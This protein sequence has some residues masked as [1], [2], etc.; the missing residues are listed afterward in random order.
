MVMNNSLLVLA[1]HLFDGERFVRSPVRIDIAGRMIASVRPLEETGPADPGGLEAGPEVIDARGCLVV[2]G[3]IN[4]HT[5]V[6]RGGMFRPDEPVSIA[7]IV[8]N[9]GDLLSAGVTTVGEMGNAP[10][11]V[12]SLRALFARRPDWGPDIVACGPLLTVE[13]G[14]PLDWMPWLARIAGVALPC[15][16]PVAG[17]NAVRRVAG[18]G[19]DHIKIVIMH[20]SYAEK[21]LPTMDLETATAV[22][23]EAH[24]QG[25]RALC[26]AHYPEDY[27]KALAAGV[28]ALLHSCFEPIDDAMVERF[29]ASG[30]F[31]G[32]TLSVFENALKG[33]EQRWDRDPRYLRHVSRNVARD[34]TEFCE[35]YERSGDIVPAGIAGGL[36]KARGREAVASAKA[37]FKKLI[38]RGVPVVFGTDAS[39]GF[40]LLGRPVDEFMAMQDA[41]MSPG[42]CLRS[43]TTTA[44]G[45][46]GLPDRGSIEPERQADLV[47]LPSGAATDMS[48]IGN[49]VGVIRAGKLHGGGPFAGSVG[50]AATGVSILSGVGRSLWWSLKQSRG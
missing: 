43:A 35:Q 3:L 14:Y 2:P 13:G 39:Y 46:L 15:P 31:Y 50:A 24:E 25:M 11:L 5:H 48:E 23:R 32:P 47:I 45:M 18:M 38:E 34:W 9:F 44:A 37:N 21:P 20:R 36:P 4:A 6:S 16:D 27:E 7:N 8:R 40:C 29:A 28:D 12:H 1:D 19:M 22:V 26:H 30:A 42:E 17:R 33:V 10:G 49:V 41:G